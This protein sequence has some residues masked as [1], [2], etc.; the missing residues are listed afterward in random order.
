MQCGDFRRYTVLTAC[1]PKLLFK[2]DP[3]ALCS[4]ATACNALLAYLARWQRPCTLCAGKGIAR[5][6]CCSVHRL[7]L[8]LPAPAIKGGWLAM[9][10]RDY[11]PAH[12]SWCRAGIF[13]EPSLGLLPP[14]QVVVMEGDFNKH[15]RLACQLHRPAI[16]VAPGG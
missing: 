5:R 10:P 1:Y 6:M 12:N 8:R 11:R 7:Q 15:V 14:S 4:Q 16:I 9:A 2:G 3:P 13:E